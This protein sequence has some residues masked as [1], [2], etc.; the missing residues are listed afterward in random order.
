MCDFPEDKCEQLLTNALQNKQDF[1]LYLC[2]TIYR[3]RDRESQRKR[4][5]YNEIRLQHNR[6]QKNMG[7]AQGW[8]D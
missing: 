4:G 7:N 6:R 2:Y 8:K 1:L 3:K 5:N